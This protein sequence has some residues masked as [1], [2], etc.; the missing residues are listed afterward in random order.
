MLAARTKSEPRTRER[1]AE[2]A[3]EITDWQLVLHHG[4]MHGL[5]PLVYCR[6]REA[7][8]ADKVPPAV[9][10][11]LCDVYAFSS[12]RTLQLTAELGR[13]LDLLED[14]SI[15]AL[16]TKGPVLGTSLYAD[17]GLRPFVDLDVIVRT[18]H[19]DAA[20]E[21]LAAN[22]YRVPQQLS[23]A[24]QRI[25]RRTTGYAAHLI[26]EERRVPLDLH[27][28]FSHGYFSAGLPSHLVWKET[29][30]MVLAGRPTTVPSPTVLLLALAIHGA[31]HGPFPWPKLKWVVDVDGFL[32]S[33]PPMDWEALIAVSE[34]IGCRRILLLGI[35]LASKLLDSPLPK[36]LSQALDR[37]PLAWELTEPIACRLFL[38]G[39]RS[40]PLG[41]RMR[42]DLR[43]RERRVDRARYLV[44]RLTQPST[45][46]LDAARL[47][48]KWASL[49]LPLR[50]ARLAG[51]YLGKP[52]RMKGLLFG[53]RE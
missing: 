53:P 52:G 18:E 36:E 10:R 51:T 39:D 42:L 43:L 44:S 38:P 48:S 3:G 45:R 11:D 1:L 28:G 26:H 40:I 14:G 17:P 24:H 13:I 30:S 37:D 15:P 32:R 21:V 47:P 35:A 9:T 5:L 6:L 27:W 25:R 20:I 2:V 4:F 16:P 22:G 8:V 34:E 23:E 41:E 46:D 50:L 31:K 33:D 12:A 49:Y 7:E 29:R 19:V